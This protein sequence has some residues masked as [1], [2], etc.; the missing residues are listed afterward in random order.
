V[1]GNQSKRCAATQSAQYAGQSFGIDAYCAQE[2]Y[3]DWQLLWQI[4]VFIASVP[5]QVDM[6][7]LLAEPQFERRRRISALQSAHSGGLRM[8]ADL[9]SEVGCGCGA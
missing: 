1:S 3:C 5:E 4:A 7:E 6:Q 9:P 8:S 2:A